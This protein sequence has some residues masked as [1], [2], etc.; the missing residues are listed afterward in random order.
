MATSTNQF[1]PD[2]A[3]SPGLV[4]QE[5]LEVLGL[6]Q[7][8]FARRCDRTPQLISEILSGKAPVDPDTA[9][10]LEQ[11]TGLHASIWLGIESDYRSHLTRQSEA[12]QGR[13]VAMARVAP[14]EL[15]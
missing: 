8:E 5:R 3:V 11:V 12:E 6:S 9:I 10:Q 7:A 1:N 2:Y 13:T 15:P 4:L 14:L